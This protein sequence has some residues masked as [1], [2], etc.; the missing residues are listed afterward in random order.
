MKL[1]PIEQFH[2]PSWALSSLMHPRV[3]YVA[4]KFPNITFLSIDCSSISSMTLMTWDLTG[5]PSLVIFN[6]RFNL[7]DHTGTATSETL[8]NLLQIYT[9]TILPN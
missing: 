7:A 6:S 3:E 2:T 8:I 4:Q 5:L 9:G 1:T